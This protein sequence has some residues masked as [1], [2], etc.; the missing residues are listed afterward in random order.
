MLYLL[1]G[2]GSIYFVEF[3]LGHFSTDLF[4]YILKIN[5]AYPQEVMKKKRPVKAFHDFTNPRNKCVA[6]SLTDIHLYLAMHLH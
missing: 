2:F 3:Y 5:N 1:T 4:V 6:N